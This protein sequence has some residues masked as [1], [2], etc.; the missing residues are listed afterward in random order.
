MGSHVVSHIFLRRVGFLHI[1]SS[2]LIASRY[3]EL[4]RSFS[5]FIYEQSY[6]LQLDRYVNVHVCLASVRVAPTLLVEPRYAQSERDVFCTTPC[7][8]MRAVLLPHILYRLTMSTVR[9]LSPVK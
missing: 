5:V 6:V 3:V 8:H 1:V 2:H 4:R 7:C 9:P